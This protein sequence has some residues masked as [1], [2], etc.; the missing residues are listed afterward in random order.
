MR[1]DRRSTRRQCPGPAETESGLLAPP[2]AER[3][4]ARL[5][6]DGAKKNEAHGDGGWPIV[7]KA[8]DDHRHISGQPPRRCVAGDYHCLPGARQYLREL[9]LRPD[10]GRLLTTSMIAFEEVFFG[11]HSLDQERF[12]ECWRDAMQLLAANQVREAA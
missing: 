9:R 7:E 5:S 4:P 12:E 8:K 10:L 11:G 3:G 6:D 2:Y 1:N